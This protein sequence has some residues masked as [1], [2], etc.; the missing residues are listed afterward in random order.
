MIT[1]VVIIVMV[2]VMVAV[3]VV[4]VVRRRS[5]RGNRHRCRV[6][7]AEHYVGRRMLRRRRRRRFVA[8]GLF[9]LGQ[10]GR[11]VVLVRRA[12][13]LRAVALAVT[14]VLAEIARRADDELFVAARLCAAFLRAVRHHFVVFL[15]LA[16]R[17]VELRQAQ[18]LAHV[19]ADVCGKKERKSFDSCC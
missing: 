10:V 8:L 5:H 19:V 9:D 12:A 15:Q 7:V 11:R 18:A 4:V 17:Q 3:V 13:I 2:M 1:V 16:R 6:V 14:K